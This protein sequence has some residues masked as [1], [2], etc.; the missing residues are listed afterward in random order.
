MAK[1]SWL[2]IGLPSRK[3]EDTKRILS[4]LGIT[5]VCKEAKCPNVNEC[6]GRGTATFMVLGD[7]CTRGCKFCNTKT[8]QCGREVDQ[9]EPDRIAKAV[10]ALNLNYVVI[11]SVDRDDLDDLGAGHF[12]RCVAE[13]K[14]KTNARV[15]VLTPDFQG[16]TSLV[17]MVCEVGPEVFGHNVET[18]ERLQKIVRDSRCDYE[19]SLKVLR[20]AASKHSGIITKSA[21]MVGM[22]E[23]VEEVIG[24]LED[25]RNAGVRA[26]AI[27]QYLQPTKRHYPVKEYVTPGKFAAYEK[28]AREMG[29][30]FVE[31]G[32]FVR[33]SYKAWEMF[34]TGY[35]TLC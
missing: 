34:S 31:C 24:T 11:T 6:W 10:L 7:V 3:Y 18:V 33:S 17:D 1:P 8:A 15:E 26:V 20:H 35:N 27:G 12:A 5:T 16:K 2:K 13:V 19:T 4:S 25:L 22:G 30:D 28:A 32:P 9:K 14:K 21:L 29:F 23:S